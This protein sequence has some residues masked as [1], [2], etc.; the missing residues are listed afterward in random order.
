MCDEKACCHVM[1]SHDNTRSSEAGSEQKRSRDGG[2]GSAGARWMDGWMEGAEGEWEMLRGKDGVFIAAAVFIAAQ[3][4]GEERVGWG[5]GL[6]WAFSL[7]RT[8][9][10]GEMREKSTELGEI[11]QN[12]TRSTLSTPASVC[13]CVCVCVSLRDTQETRD[14]KRRAE[15][16]IERGRGGPQSKHIHLWIRDP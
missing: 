13:V 12:Q 14:E 2:E 10:G 5:R 7:L 6:G 1:V 16:Q 9:G 4:R 3:R 8:T 11:C 15:K